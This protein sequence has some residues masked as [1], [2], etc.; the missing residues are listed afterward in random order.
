MFPQSNNSYF[1]FI[2]ILKMCSETESLSL[3]LEFENYGRM[4]NQLSLLEIAAEG[5]YGMSGGSCDFSCH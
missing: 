2:V 4:K 3:S 1:V 5:M